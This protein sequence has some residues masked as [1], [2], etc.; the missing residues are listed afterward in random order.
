[1]EVDDRTRI[2]SAH[3]NDIGHLLRAVFNYESVD[4][5]EGVLSFNLSEENVDGLK[6][7]IEAR[8]V[9]LSDAPLVAR[10]FSAGSL[11]GLANLMNDQGINLTQAY[12]EFEI[13][14]NILGVS[15]FRA[16]GPSVGITADGAVALGPDGDIRL[17]GALAPFY[18]INSL[19]GNAPIFGELFVGKKGEGIVA[20]SYAISGK[21]Q[22]PNVLINPLSALTPGIFRQIMQPTDP[23]SQITESAQEPELQEE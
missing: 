5:G 15:N 13:A 19:L 23:A 17:D 4:G 14:N 3:S 9:T 7:E 20:L 18:Q 2:I 1:M 10:L 12:G 22:S 6:G 8:N 16:T 11:D 21:R